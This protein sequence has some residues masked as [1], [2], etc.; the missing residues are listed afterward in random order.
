MLFI[1]YLFLLIILY[2]DSI[3]LTVIVYFLNYISVV[4]LKYI[5]INVIFAKN[6]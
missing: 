3:F 2:H 6:Q 5:Y 1:Q 4:V